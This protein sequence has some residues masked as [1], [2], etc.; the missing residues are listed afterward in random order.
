MSDFVPNSFQHPNLY[1]DGYMH[2]LTG[3][4]FKVLTYAVR[5]IFGFNKRQDRI[6]LSQF[7]SGTVSRDDGRQLDNGTGL[8]NQTVRRCLAVLTKANLVK[9]IADN[10]PKINEGTLYALELDS[11]KVD[12]EWLTQQHLKRSA[13]RTM[14][15]AR[16]VLAQKATPA[17]ADTPSADSR[18][19]G[20]ADS[21]APCYPIATQYTEETQGKHN[22]GADAPK[23]PR[24]P[25]ERQL[26]LA[27]LEKSFS[28]FTGLPL[29]K[30]AT[31]K[32]KKAGAT[33]WWTPLG[34]LYELAGKNTE[35]A[36]SLIRDAIQK[37][38][39]DKLM[40]TAPRSVEAIAT[41]IFAERRAKS[42]PSTVGPR[43]TAPIR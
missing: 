43:Q 38:R 22:P 36:E 20:T 17:M 24:K 12:L 5:R 10:D 32:E 6:S 37:M 8:S 27:I 28:D 3:E 18:G 1:V 33:G 26:A 11:K 7:V 31:E 42:L 23:A 19:G 35:Q 40:I 29:P 34:N 2:L 15:T 25:T 16:T 9:K 41:A 13:S 14:N 39:T 21:S 4:E 30:R